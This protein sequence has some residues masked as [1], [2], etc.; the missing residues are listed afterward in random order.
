MI[1]WTGGGFL[2]HEGR[3]WDLADGADLD[4]Y[5]DS[6]IGEISPRTHEE[7]KAETIRRAQNLGEALLRVGT[8]K[9]ILLW[10]TARGDGDSRGLSLR[11]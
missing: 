11:R 5:R 4:A 6:M 9:G 2:D 7:Y 1:F 3:P 10:E 8:Q